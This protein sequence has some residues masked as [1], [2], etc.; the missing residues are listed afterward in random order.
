MAS[1]PEIIWCIKVIVVGWSS[2][3]VGVWWKTIWRVGEEED[4]ATKEVSEDDD[5]AFVCDA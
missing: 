2:K 4:V 1:F 3:K 5:D